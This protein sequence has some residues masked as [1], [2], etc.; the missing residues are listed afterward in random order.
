ML[1]GFI[2]ICLTL[3]Y[4]YFSKFTQVDK[5]VPRPKPKKTPTTTTGKMVKKAKD[6]VIA[7]SLS[8]KKKPAAAEPKSEGVVSK[9][10]KE[11]SNRLA[12]AKH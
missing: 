11:I 6:K 5:P 7:S 4:V 12:E 2:C 8:A 10:S 3:W 9:K 1:H